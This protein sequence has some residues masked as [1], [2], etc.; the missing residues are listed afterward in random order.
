LNFLIFLFLIY[1]FAL[2][3]V[4]DYLNKRRGA[5][6]AAVDEGEEAKRRSEALLADYRSRLARLGDELGA[7]RD[8]L[9]ADADQEKSKLLAEAV[10]AELARFAE[11]FAQPELNGVLNNP[12][13]A[14]QA[15]KNIVSQIARALELSPLMI[16][17]LLLLADHDRLSFYPG[18]VERYRRMLDE[19][20][21]Q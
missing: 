3:L 11:V 20:K 15:R 2:P 14:A 21:G 1:R 5:I 6:A 18:I 4:R 16:H 9:R 17:F 12:G 19:K 8:R 10:A 13:F 7:I